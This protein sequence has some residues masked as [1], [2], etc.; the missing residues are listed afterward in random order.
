M[1]KRKRISLIVAAAVIAGLFYVAVWPFIVGG[2][3]MQAFCQSLITDMPFAQVRDLA[4]RNGYRCTAPIRD[5]RVLI[6][7]SRSFGRFVCD[8]QF[9]EER[10]VSARYQSND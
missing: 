2:S 3:K 6:H 10:L 5:G 8:A 7:E 9:N 4:E 1:T